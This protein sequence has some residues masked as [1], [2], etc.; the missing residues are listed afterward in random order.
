MIVAY[1]S[2]RT[3]IYHVGREMIERVRVTA[4][5]V[6]G[7][8]TRRLNLLSGISLLIGGLLTFVST[9][10][11][12]QIIR[13]NGS[14]AN[15]AQQSPSLQSP[16]WLMLNLL[17]VLG[18][19]LII[20]AFPAMFARLPKQ[21]RWLGLVGLILTLAAILMTGVFGF[22]LNIISIPSLDMSVISLLTR[23]G[24]PDKDMV[25]MV[26][27]L[28]FSMGTIL[29]GLAS[30]RAGSTSGLVGAGWMFIM[31]GLFNV[32]HLVSIPD[33]YWEFF[34]LGSGEI[35]SILTFY[36]GLAAYGFALISLSEP[37][38]IVRRPLLYGMLSTS[39]IVSYVVVVGS[40]GV[41]VQQT[42]VALIVSLLAIGL[43]AI[44]FQPLRNYLQQAVNHLIYGERDNPHEVLSQLGKHMESTLA[45]ES[46]LPTIVETIA[47]SLKLPYAAIALKQEDDL[48]VAAVYGSPM[49]PQQRF[50]L[51]YQAEQLGELVLSPRS[52]GESLTPADQRLL[53]ELAP[54]IGVAVN[55]VRL[56][57]DLQR[58]RERLVTAREEERRRLRRD[59]HDGLGPQL[60]SQTLTLTAAR[61]LL[62][63]DPDAAEAL[64]ADA[65]VQVQHAITDIRRLVYA[66]RPPALDDLGLI[67]AL[68]E[69]IA[70]YQASGVS[71][72]LD[73]PENLPDLAAA[74]EVACYRITQE[75]LTNVVRHAKARDCT[76]RIAMDEVLALEIADDGIGLTTSCTP[77]VGFSTMRERAEELGG[78][79]VIES[80]PTGGTCVY[81]QL[82]L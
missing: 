28:L 1:N 54:Q 26:D 20:I 44:L 52:F 21:A 7:M 6:L 39:V 49:E 46:I 11:L 38:Q 53:H 82:P 23:V 77:G 75:A 35:L 65:I 5:R 16:L 62:R 50:P 37:G 17:E 40:I 4:R 81:A 34:F 14:N 74:V 72:R 64:L 55:A 22:V 33:P 2:S 80:R 8:S 9:A 15:T 13:M 69:Q 45:P 61:R 67:A 66:L 57:V 68:R 71:F 70:Q 43:V 29:F 42:G 58:S 27:N 18:S 59:L 19:L 31:A 60:A 3:H 41:L 56:T 73:A 30:V 24:T 63:V 51:V 47:R 10:I 76:I 48:T 12:F 79:C 36:F 25:F 78:R 32:V